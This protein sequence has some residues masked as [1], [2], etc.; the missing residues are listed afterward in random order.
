MTIR[1]IL[2]AAGLSLLTNSGGLPRSKSYP[3]VGARTPAAHGEVRALAPGS[4]F[5]ERLHREAAHTYEISLDAGQLL[6]V[7]IKKKDL[8]LLLTCYG[9]D[10]RKY[11][12]RINGD[13]EPLTVSLIAEAAGLYRLE[14]RSLEKDGEAL[15]YEM[16]VEEVRDATASDRQYEAAEK[17]FARADNLCARWEESALREAVGHYTDAW[18]SWHAIGRDREATRALAKAGD[19]YYVLSDYRSALGAYERALTMSR[20]RDDGPAEAEALSNVGYVHVYLG[21]NRKALEYLRAALE[22]LG[23]L[24]PAPEES[25]GRRAEAHALNNM[26]EAYYS[27]TELKKSLDYFGRALALWRAAGDRRGQALAHLNLGYSHADLGDLPEAADN[28]SRALSLWEAVGDR[29]GEALSR[30]ALGGVHSSRGEKQSALDAHSRALPLFRAMGNLQGEAASLNG[31]G[32]AYEDLGEK[33][34]ALDHYGSALRLYQKIANRDFAALNKYLIG[35][36]HYSMENI[37]QA[38]EF[39]EQSR[40]LSRAVGDRQIEAYTL[41]GLGRVYDSRGEQA[42]ALAHYNAGLGLYRKIGDR[43]GQ[44]RALNSI[45]YA[46]YTSGAKRAA[47][48]HFEKALPLSRAVEDRRDVALTLYNIARAELDL[49]NR[50][51]ALTR[52]LESVDI[53]ES[54]RS[55]VVGHDLR[56]SYFASVHQFYELHIELLMELH[57]QSPSEGLAAA[58]LQASERA[59]ARSLLETL[60]EKKADIRYG[61]DPAVLERER[62]VQELLD[63]KAEYRMRLLNGEHTAEQV[64]E[65]S[66]EIRE[67]EVA[68]R[69]VQARIKEQSPRYAALTQPQSSGLEEIQKALGGENTI[70]LEY[71]LGRDRSY[72]WAVTSTTLDSYEL[73]AGRALEEGAR[74]L[75]EA[76][77]A[78]QPKPGETQAQHRER[79]TAADAQYRRQA[80]ALSDVLL[81]PVADRLGD[82]RLLVVSDGT[83]QY[84]PFEALPAPAPHGRDAERPEDARPLVLAHEVVS[85]PSASVLVAIRR[86]QAQAAPLPPK[87]VAVLADPVFDSDDPRVQTQD[88]PVTD[89]N[90]NALDDGLDDVSLRRALRDFGGGLSIPRLPFSRR[91]A[92]AIKAVT[93]DGKVTVSADFDASR[94]TALGADL[95][96]HRIVHF[97]THGVLDAEHPELSGVVLSLVDRRG[98]RQDGFLRLQDIYNLDLPVELVVLSACQSALGK[99]V[100]GEGLIALTRGF[101]HAGS[102]SVVASLWKVDD[103]A[104]AE[105]MKHFYSAMLEE[106]LPPPVALQAAKVALWKQERWRPPYFWAAF[107]LQGEYKTAPVPAPGRRPGARAF[108]LA[109]VAVVLFLAGYRAFR[110]ARKETGGA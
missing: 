28:Y 57:K 38:F 16:R 9:A 106:G 31:I 3:A 36:V 14:L 33:Q 59:R 93:P 78:R 66:R 21:E 90:A 5:A 35:R 44:A 48:A 51:G 8:A 95:G 84:I 40:L 107:V 27:L 88:A 6:R 64:E 69:D 102:K 86:G 105:L 45:G 103:E 110:R 17:A 26:G 11:F 22:R 108:L 13:Y 42:Q 29:R 1:L 104:T 99:N 43:R 30:T 67:L 94:A 61:V 68:Y 24:R 10:G 109:A 58:A 39:F 96:R 41:M 60:A 82:K 85:L 37:G 53:A 34:T 7:L 89:V 19:T 2:F 75:Y 70:L 20:R 52:I 76:L 98:A 25:G 50:R 83:L 49:G 18:K 23:R 55:K 62:T 12:E 81:G 74:A 15:P 80:A 91:E 73:P 32:Q 4:T 54:L 71:A 72:L 47:L 100:K 65:V 97:A 92:E 56:A 87:T 77:T 46:Y 101:M 79:V 63:A